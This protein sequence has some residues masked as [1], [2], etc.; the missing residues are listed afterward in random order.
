MKNKC[1]GKWSAK[2][3][4]MTLDPSDKCSAIDAIRGKRTRN[5]SRTRYVTL[6]SWIYFERV[7]KK[8][9]HD[10][11]GDTSFRIRDARRSVLIFT[12]VTKSRRYFRVQF[13]APAAIPIYPSPLCLRIDSI[14]IRSRSAGG[15]AFLQNETNRKSS[16]KPF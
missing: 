1:R 9:A 7:T 3:R 5:A 8:R 11:V 14:S 15:S 13:H 6:R 2:V 12:R 4:L 10:S 16:M